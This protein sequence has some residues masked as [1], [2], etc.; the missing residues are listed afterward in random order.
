MP[1]SS[2]PSR[3]SRLAPPPV[4]MWPNARLV[5]AE[6]A[7]GGRRVAAADDRQPVDLGQRL[8]DRAGAVGERVDLEDAHRAVPEDRP[9]VGE[10]GGE[11]RGRLRPDVEAEAV[12]R[13]PVGRHDPRL[14]VAV[15]RRE[16]GVDHDV[17]RQHDLD[18]GL[19]GP[20]EVAA[21]GV[22]LVLL[23]QAL[24]DLVALGGLRKVKTMPPPI[25]SLSALPS[26]LSITPSLSETFEPPSTTTYGR[27]GSLGEPPQHVDLGRHQAAHRRAA[28][29]ARRRT[30]RPACGA[31]RRSRRRRT[32]RPA[33]RAGRRTRRARRRPCW[34]RPALKRTFSSSATWPSLEPGD[35]LRGA[36]AH[37]VGG[38]GDRPTEQLAEPRRDRRQGVR[39]VRRALGPAEVGDHDDPGAGVGERLDGRHAGADPA[40]V[41]DRAC[42]RAAR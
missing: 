2:L 36:L 39:R 26:R 22:E 6:L 34:S 17:G 29:A 42:R 40:V 10:L 28:A 3:Y 31:R 37:G 41:G 7:H 14:G 32:R 11:R 18:A 23:E 20:L 16:L 33:R 38:E 12:G 1:G 21:A 27:S 8:G 15:A 19:A 35:G 4:E 30:R 25:S 9:R 24:A 13:D 5:E